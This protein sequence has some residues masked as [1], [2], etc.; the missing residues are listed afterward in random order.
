MNEHRTIGSPGPSFRPDPRCVS[1]SEGGF[2][3]YLILGLLVIFSV[4]GIA[5]LGMTDDTGLVT[6]GMAR[7][8]DRSRE[9]DGWLEKAVEEVRPLDPA[10]SCSTHVFAAAIGAT[11]TCAQT[12]TTDSSGH[13]VARDIQIGVAA[14]GTTEV[15]GRARMRTQDWV[16]NS[17]L[18]GYSIETCDWQ[19]SRQVSA[20]LKSC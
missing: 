20:T 6:T 17:A 15:A 3:L 10:T 8:T 9:V 1:H 13:V 2:I 16:N 19:V 12:V 5:L 7:S 18:P 14:T 11:V 4:V